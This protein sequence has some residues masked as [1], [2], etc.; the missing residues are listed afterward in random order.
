LNL[1]SD[2][3]Q[4]NLLDLDSLNWS[5]FSQGLD[6][7]WDLDMASA[8][9][10]IRKVLSKS[11]KGLSSQQRAISLDLMACGIA[12]GIWDDENVA[13][14]RL[15]A[16]WQWFKT[17]TEKNA[18]LGSL[19]KGYVQQEDKNAKSGG[20]TLEIHTAQLRVQVDTWV[21]WGWLYEKPSSKAVKELMLDLGLRHYQG[22]WVKG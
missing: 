11:V 20:R 12:A 4:N 13:L 18:S 1:T 16:Y 8:F 10:T 17:E 21:S 3:W 9:V 22:R 19:L 2:N 14:E 6:D 7:F 15:K 5:G